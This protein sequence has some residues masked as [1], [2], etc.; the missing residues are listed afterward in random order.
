MQAIIGE[1]SESHSLTRP[2][3]FVVEDEADI[4]KLICYH[5]QA[6]GY[7]TQ[8]FPDASQVIAEAEKV[9]PALFLLDVML[10]TQNG[11][12]LCRQ[13]RRNRSLQG[14]RIIFLSARTGERDRVDGLELG[15]DAYIGKPFSPRELVAR[16]RAML[17]TRSTAEPASVA[18]FGRVEID[19]LSMTVKVAGTIIPTTIREF[20]LLEYLTRH[21]SRVFTRKQ[22]L[23]AVLPEASFVTERSIDVYVRRL[24]IKIEPDSDR[25][26][27]IKTVRGVGYRFEVP[28]EQ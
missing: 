23:D 19:Q 17:R 6:S 5:L 8:W 12:D 1:S 4:G 2:L 7:A 13:I 18:S 9:L 22:L 11:F 25:P 16:V 21:P 27:Y 15:G 24:R 28:R 20:R 26:T 14:T 3:I 10:P